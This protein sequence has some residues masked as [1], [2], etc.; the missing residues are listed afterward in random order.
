MPCKQ[1]SV[2]SDDREHSHGR[3]A[4][5]TLKATEIAEGIDFPYA[6]QVLQL[7]RKTRRHRGNRLHTEVVYAITSLSHR[8]AHPNQ[9]AA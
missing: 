5:R 6:V 4:R 1:I 8:D 9:I 2:L 7:T 3:A